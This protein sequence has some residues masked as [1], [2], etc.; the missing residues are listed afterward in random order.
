MIS[1]FAYSCSYFFGLRQFWQSP[2]F[3]MVINNVFSMESSH[4]NKGISSKGN[5]F[6]ADL[7]EFALTPLFFLS[8]LRCFL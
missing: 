1:I 4:R 5:I 8:F 6:K 2:K 3:R 7:S